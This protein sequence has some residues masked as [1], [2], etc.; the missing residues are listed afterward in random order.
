MM[1]GVAQVMGMKPI[2]RRVFS[3]G[4]EDSRNACLAAARGKKLPIADSAVPAPTAR[5]KRRRTAS[6]GNSARITA[7]STARSDTTSGRLREIVL[8]L[9]GMTTAGTGVATQLYVGIERRTEETHSR[10]RLKG[11]YLF[12]AIAMPISE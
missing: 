2:F 3:R 10:L 9:A 12:N 6:C 1:I 11:T 8:S 5:K 7:C 4:P